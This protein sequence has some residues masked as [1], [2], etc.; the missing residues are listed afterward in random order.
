[1]QNVGAMKMPNKVKSCV[2]SEGKN[3]PR[4]TSLRG[5]VH[6]SWGRE[7]FYP[8]YEKHLSHGHSFHFKENMFSQFTKALSSW[9]WFSIHV[10]A[11]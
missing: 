2:W 1:M 11:I 5:L 10:A 8:L 9:Y 3:N 7:W 6:A 4:A